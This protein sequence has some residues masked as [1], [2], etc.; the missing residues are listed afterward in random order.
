MRDQS[1]ETLSGVKDLVVD[2]QKATE[3]SVSTTKV[4][5]FPLEEWKGAFMDL[6]SSTLATVAKFVISCLP[7]YV[8][9]SHISLM[10]IGG[11]VWHDDECCLLVFPLDNRIEFNFS[12]SPV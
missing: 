2:H 4:E 3:T 7:K 12:P 6:F 1:Q 8:V 9:T 5:K 11:S 10:S